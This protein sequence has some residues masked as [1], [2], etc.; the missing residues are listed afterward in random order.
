MDLTGIDESVGDM[1]CVVAC[2]LYIFGTFASF[3]FDAG[4]VA[5]LF[6][7]FITWKWLD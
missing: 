5:L 7:I 3:T 2:G 6:Y 4:L 1:F